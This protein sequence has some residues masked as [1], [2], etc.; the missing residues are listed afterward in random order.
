MIIESVKIN[1]NIDCEGYQVEL[2]GYTECVEEAIDMNKLIGEDLFFSEDENFEET[3]PE[4]LFGGAYYCPCCGDLIYITKVIY[5]KPAVIAIWSDG[6]KT[7]ST[8]DKDD[9]WNPELGLM[10]CVM[11]KLQ[12]QAFVSKL[13]RDWAIEVSGTELATEE[14]PIAKTLTLKDVRKNLKDFKDAKDFE[15]RVTNS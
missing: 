12:G 9:I 14:N 4:P 13:F 2:T 11:K 7:R 8:C 6:T 1:N 3:R 15:K 5:N 10:L